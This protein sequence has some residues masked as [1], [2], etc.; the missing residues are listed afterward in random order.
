MNDTIAEIT[1]QDHGPAVTESAPEP[2]YLEP[3]LLT[4]RLLNPLV[5]HLVKMGFS[6]KG[7]RELHVRGRSTGEWRTVPVNLLELEDA[8]YLVAPRGNTQWVRNLRVAGGGRLGRGRRVTEFV[9][10]EVADADKAPIVRA[11]L[12]AWAFEVGRFFEG[13][14]ADSSDERI[15]NVAAGFPVFEVTLT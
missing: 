3:D 14:D 5:T 7:A 2:R 15:A 4:R 11:Y 8:T 10:A 13:V 12:R 9:A 1:N 6:V